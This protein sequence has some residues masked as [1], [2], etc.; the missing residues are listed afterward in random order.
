ML[1]GIADAELARSQV[2]GPLPPDPAASARARAELLSEIAAA[3]QRAEELAA[4]SAAAD[5]LGRLADTERALAEDTRGMDAER[6]AAEIGD[7]QEAVA[8]AA[9]EAAERLPADAAA[10]IERA[11][12]EAARKIEGG[13]PAS[14]ADAQENAAAAMDAAAE[15][16][17]AQS[18]AETARSNA[19]RAAVDRAA[20]ETLF[21][22]ERQRAVAERLAAPTTGVGDQA[23]R[24]AR[25]R[26]VVQG[27]DRTLAALIEAIGGRPAAAELARLLAESVYATRRAEG[28]LAS[29]T[30]TGRIGDRRARAAADEAAGSLALLARAFLLPP[31]GMKIGGAQG[32]SAESGSLA[33]QLDAMASAQRSIADAA[34]R[35]D[36][37]AGGNPEAAAAERQL[38]RELG[39]LEA[40]LEAQGIDARAVGALLEAVESA[41]RQLERGLPGAREETELQSLARRFADIGRM[42]QQ[43]EGERRAEA[44]RGFVPAAPPPLPARTTARR[45]DPEAALA[46]WASSLPRPALAPARA[47]LERLADEGVRAAGGEP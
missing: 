41:A 5:S 24:V 4:R 26:V 11:L 22:A 37:P 34:A 27:L 8:S 17:R 43:R 36:D 13:D 42:V 16:A 23:D 3:L 2:P 33:R 15:E 19:R 20:G 45:L 25:Q 9:R 35:A 21:L 14:A 28:M 38:G 40:G 7:R 1:A 30:G 44:A 46:P 29:G 6:M 47:Y 31:G 10:S 12:E 32:S 18:A 39:G